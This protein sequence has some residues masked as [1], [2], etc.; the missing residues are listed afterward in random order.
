MY[1]PWL[2]THYK[3]L[4]LSLKD[5]LIFKK[6]II[7]FIMIKINYQSHYQIHYQIHYP[8]HQMNSNLNY[9]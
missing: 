1:G 8:I 7:R 2:V 4:L 6:L 3:F 5:S 9:H